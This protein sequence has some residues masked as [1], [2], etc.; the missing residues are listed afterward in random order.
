MKKFILIIVVMFF[1]ATFFIIEDRNYYREEI[2]EDKEIKA[3]YLSYMELDKYLNVNS[4]QVAKENIK[5]II[6]NLSKNHL[7]V[8]YSTNSKCFSL[9]RLHFNNHGIQGIQDQLLVSFTKRQPR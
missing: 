1:I 9:L 8:V 7:K 3:M 5:L 4:D 2:V 6:N